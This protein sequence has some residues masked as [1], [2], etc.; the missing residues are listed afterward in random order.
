MTTEK[1]EKSPVT[2]FGVPKDYILDGYKVGDDV[3]IVDE[4]TPQDKS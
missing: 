4:F 3:I 2:Y 1:T